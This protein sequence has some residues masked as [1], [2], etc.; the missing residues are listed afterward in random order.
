MKVG[1]WIRYYKNGWHFAKLMKLGYKWA[2]VLHP[3][4]GKLKVA[5]TDVEAWTK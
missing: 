2:V 4:R 3:T 1:E 5:I